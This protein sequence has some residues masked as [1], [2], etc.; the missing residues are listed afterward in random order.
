VNSRSVH[1]DPT[2]AFQLFNAAIANAQAEGNHALVH[3]L[4]VAKQA[5]VRDYHDGAGS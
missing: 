2:R 3:Y 1:H 5:V 4:L